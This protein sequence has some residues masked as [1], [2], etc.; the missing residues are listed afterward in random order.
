MILSLMLIYI[1][2]MGVSPWALIGLLI[3]W[4]PD[5]IL[6]GVCAGK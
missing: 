3:T 2:M 5:V 4:I 6:I 1:V